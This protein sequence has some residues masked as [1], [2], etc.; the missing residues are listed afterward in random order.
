MQSLAG[1]RARRR[2]FARMRPGQ[3]DHDQVEGGGDGGENRYKLVVPDDVGLLQ[4]NEV[5]SE[6]ES[7]RFCKI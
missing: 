4:C 7:S 6:S 3:I 1:S 2:K 5:N